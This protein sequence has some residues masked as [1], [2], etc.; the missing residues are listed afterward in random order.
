MSIYLYPMLSIMNCL[1]SLPEP[2]LAVHHPA[3]HHPK[4]VQLECHNLLWAEQ[5]IATNVCQTLA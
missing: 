1:F 4:A 2:V 5:R 3:I